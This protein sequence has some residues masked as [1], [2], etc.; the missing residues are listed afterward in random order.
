MV[1]VSQ[2]RAQLAKSGDRQRQ[3]AIG[4]NDRDSIGGMALASSVAIFSKSIMAV[5]AVYGV[6]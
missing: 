4:G 6:S 1:L 2:A 5:G 3:A